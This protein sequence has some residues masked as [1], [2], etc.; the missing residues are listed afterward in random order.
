MSSRGSAAMIWA[1]GATQVIGYGTLYYA[2]SVLAPAIGAEFGWPP[3]WVFGAL[4]LALLAGG[5]LAPWAGH[6]ADRFGAA[7][8][9]VVGSVAAALLLG[10]AGLAWDGYSFALA[11]VGMEMASSLVLYATA[12]AALVQAGAEG[13]QRRITYLTLIAG[14]A[15]TL[16]WPLT[17]VL[18]EHLGWRG[19]YFVF[20]ALN[21]VV[22]APLHLWLARRAPVAVGEAAGTSPHAVV[23]VGVLPAGRRNLAP[24]LMMAGFA[25]EGLVLSGVLLQIMPI[26]QGLSLGAGALVITTLFG[27]AQVLSRLVNMLVGRDLRATWLAVIAA[28][29]LPAGLA[30]L[31][32]TAPSLP[33][34]VVFAVLFGLGSGLTSIV[35]GAL[36]LYLLGRDRYGARLGWLSSARQV[37]SAIAPFLLAVA[38]GALGVGGA[39][40]VFVALGLVAVSVFVAVEALVPRR[41]VIVS[42]GQGG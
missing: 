11:L 17:A 35:S 5:L 29:L 30:V 39:L 25:I 1:L 7:R 13:A 4:S 24:G 34:A 19:C 2:F 15:S 33:G 41:A 36:P 22:C 6:L 42:Q 14:F 23:E 16:F 37:A 32:A 21:L 40:W 3:E 31:L 12:F 8:T 20:A 28:A 10:A 27:P 18:L 38:M 9:M 26:I